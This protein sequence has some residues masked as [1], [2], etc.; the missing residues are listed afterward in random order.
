[1]SSTWPRHRRLG[2]DRGPRG[3]GSKAPPTYTEP[4]VTRGAEPDAHSDLW[5]LGV[6]AYELLTG[7]S[8]WGDNLNLAELE[9]R[10]AHADPPPIVAR[11]GGHAPS[12]PPPGDD[13]ARRARSAA[14]SP[15]TRAGSRTS[16][17]SS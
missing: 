3:A 1:M 2:L 9:Q 16:S 6:M 17:R 4:E 15:A 12:V 10:I 14:A 8:P 5:A 11:S 7:R 13:R